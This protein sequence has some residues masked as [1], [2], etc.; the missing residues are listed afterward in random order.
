[1]STGDAEREVYQGICN[2]G[3]KHITRFGVEIMYLWI[4]SVQTVEGRGE[5]EMI[6][7]KCI[8]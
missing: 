7:S 5:D 4:F 8:E 1:M 2:V 3:L 6:Q